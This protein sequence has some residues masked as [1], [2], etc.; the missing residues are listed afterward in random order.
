MKRVLVEGISILMLS[1]LITLLF[2]LAS[3][4]G[5]ILLK[6]AFGIKADP[7]KVVAAENMSYRQP[8]L[9]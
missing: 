1:L 8:R 9:P 4:S 5:I 7:G 6:K 2:N 3:P